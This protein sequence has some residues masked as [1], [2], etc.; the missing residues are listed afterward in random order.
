MAAVQ[1]SPAQASALG[2]LPSSGVVGVGAGRKAVRTVRRGG[3][4]SEPYHTRCHTCATDFTTRAGETRHLDTT[5][6]C[7]YELIDVYHPGER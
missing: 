3:G 6:H 4:R 1:L 2:V 5:G 7:R